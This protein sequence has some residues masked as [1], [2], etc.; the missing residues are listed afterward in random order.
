MFPF[1]HRNDLGF[2]ENESFDPES[3]LG[4]RFIFRRHMAM[5]WPPIKGGEPF[6]EVGS[7]I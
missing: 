7:S 6:F 2:E 1:C 4:R 5:P 3:R